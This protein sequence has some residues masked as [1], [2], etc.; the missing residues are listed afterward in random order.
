MKRSDEPI[1]LYLDGSD[2]PFKIAIPPLSFRFSTLKLSDGP[3]ELRV[4]ASNGLAP[5]T[6]RRVPF[7]VRNGVA[8][9]ASGVKS[10]ETISGDVELIVNA[11]AGSSEVDFEPRQAETPQPAPIWFWVLLL[12]IASWGMFYLLRPDHVAR[13]DEFTPQPPD[14]HAGARIYSD[15]C[16]R[17][18]GVQGE[19]VRTASDAPRFTVPSLRHTPNLSVAPS[20]AALLQKV[21]V[22]APDSQMPAWGPLLTRRDLVDVVN[23]VRT[24]WGHDASTIALAHRAAPRPIGA[25]EA[26][27]RTAI[28][29]RNADALAAVAWPAGA[30]PVLFR[31]GTPPAGPQAARRC[32]SGGGRTSRHWRR[33]LRP[34]FGSMRCDTTTRRTWCTTRGPW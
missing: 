8:I 33:V 1:K 28:R 14:P 18:H 21:I 2:E 12:A 29:E 4:E 16:A 22:G 31:A 27:I 15:T 25:L 7:E 17:C 9:S 26:Q 10:G 13:P 11:F 20:P 24:A 5:P 19:G 32:P 6:I 30:R 23:H 3:H 34:M